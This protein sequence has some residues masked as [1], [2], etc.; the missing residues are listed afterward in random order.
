MLRSVNSQP[1]VAQEF[2]ESTL[3]T[4]VRTVVSITIKCVGQ[5]TACFSLGSV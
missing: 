1:I 5:L 2:R 4:I 3:N